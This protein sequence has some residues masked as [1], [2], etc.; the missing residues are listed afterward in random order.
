MAVHGMV[1]TES[2]VLKLTDSRSTALVKK[3]EHHIAHDNGEIKFF[4]SHHF[5]IGRGRFS[6]LMMI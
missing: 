3:N 1:Y 2:Y 6:G 4:L 5:H